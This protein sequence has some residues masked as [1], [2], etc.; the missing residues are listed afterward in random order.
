MLLAAELACLSI[1]DTVGFL[2][3]AMPIAMADGSA[4]ALYPVVCGRLVIAWDAALYDSTPRLL[5]W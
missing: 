2:A 1:P 5:H 4:T 3:M